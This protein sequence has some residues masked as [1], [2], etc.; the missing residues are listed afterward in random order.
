MFVGVGAARVRKLFGELRAGQSRVFMYM[1]SVNVKHTC[2][3][4]TGFAK[5]DYIP[6]LTSDGLCCT[7]TYEPR[8]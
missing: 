8:P 2:T 6:H 3:G 7:C 1:Y 5:R 4:M